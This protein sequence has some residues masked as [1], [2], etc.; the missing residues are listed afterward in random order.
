MGFGID[1][2]FNNL[3]CDRIHPSIYRL[4]LSYL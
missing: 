3:K 4:L 2:G 1:I